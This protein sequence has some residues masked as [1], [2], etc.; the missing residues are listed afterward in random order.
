MREEYLLTGPLEPT[1][2]WYAVA[3]IAESKCARRTGDSMVAE[4]VG[5]EGAVSFD[6][7]KP[8][9]TPAKASRYL[10][11]PIPRLDPAN[12]SARRDQADIRMVCE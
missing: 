1:N 5:Y 3:K 7:V 4:T 8:D 2:E 9:G 10:P 6:P 11:H 12:H